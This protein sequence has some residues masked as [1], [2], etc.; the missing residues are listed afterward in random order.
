MAHPDRV[1]S[2]LLV[3]ASLSAP[4]PAL[5]ADGALVF[6]LGSFFPGGDSQVWTLNTETFDFDVG[7][8]NYW[9]GGVELDLELTNYLDVAIGF[10]GYNRRVESTY[11][12]F[13]RDGGAEIPQNFK[14]K[15]LPITGGLRLLPLGKFRKLI[16][17]VAVGTGLYYFDY[18]EEGDFIDGTSFEVFPGTFHDRG[19]VPGLQAGAGA[20]YMFSEGIEPGEGWYLFGQFRRHWVSAE[21]AGDFTGEKLDLGGAEIAFGLSL[22]F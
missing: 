3:L 13:V 9:M 14:L 18:Q 4:G 10:D 5:S 22:R 17:H 15:V 20:E 12:D 21:L 8:F 2:L 16:P 19:F 1:R 7:D 6:K 11:R